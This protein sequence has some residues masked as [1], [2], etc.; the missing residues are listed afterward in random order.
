MRMDTHVHTRKY[1]RLFGIPREPNPI[2][3][4][5]EKP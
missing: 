5:M 2:P 1:Y 4:N 3:T